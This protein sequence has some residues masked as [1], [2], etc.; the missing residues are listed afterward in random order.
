M[1]AH[2]ETSFM[3]GEIKVSPSH[4]TLWARNH[5]LKLQPKAMAVLHYLACNQHRVISNEEMIERLWA[6]RVVT[7]GSVQKSINS[8]RSA[9][10]ELIGENELIA[11]Y[12]KRGYQLMVEPQFLAPSVQE[13]ANESSPPE[14]TINSV[15]RIKTSHLMLAFAF[16]LFASA[17]LY[18][19]I[20]WGS[21]QLPHHHRTVFNT[22]QGYTNETGHERS[23]TP[24]PDNQHLAY[25]RETVTLAQT[26]ANTHEATSEIIIRNGAGKDWRIASSNGTWFKL[27]WSPAGKNLVAI[28]VKKRDGLPLGT[29]FYQPANYLYSFHIFA[30]DLAQEQLLEKQQLSQWQGHIFSVSWWDENTLEIVAKQ[31]PNAGNG[32]YRYSILDQQLTLLDELA[33]ITNPVASAVFDQALNK[34]TAIASLQKNKIQIDFLDAQQER[35]NNTKLDIAAADISWIP[36]GSGVLVYAED[37]RK[38][39]NVYLDG[40]QTSIPLADSKDKNFS[41]PRYSADGNSIYYTEEK[42]S[43]NITLAGLDGSKN[44]LTENTDFNYAASFSPDGKKVVYASVRNNQIHLWLIENGQERQLTQQPVPKKVDAIIWSDNGEHI[45]FNADNQ[46][47]HLN[48]LTNE[49]T[50]VVNDANKIEPIAYFPGTNRLYVIKYNGEIRNLWRIEGTQ[51]KQLTFGAV[52]SAIEYGGD[53]FFQYVSENGLWALRGK[54]DEIERSN[55]SLDEYS[56]LLKADSNGIYYL[57]GGVC[58]ESDV[59]YQ[60][61]SATSNPV[62]LVQENSAVLTTSFNPDKGLLQTECSLPEANIVQL[63]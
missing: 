60:D 24:H 7:H 56:K 13:T 32:R 31:G 27:A 42:R 20:N 54:N 46:L 21:V 17:A 8:L 43:A 35:I 33:T 44:R 36:D 23:A 15:R 5:S 37:E 30:L 11:H 38:L 14:A 45:V 29:R 49:S 61:Y 39:F 63:K 51:Q 62:I 53:V 22:T 26:A 50:L 58:Q 59:Y 3:L 25:I 10:N 9:L 41:R 48:L 40:Q 52:G 1:N 57:K 4:N 19:S 2:H 55:P 16:V 12:S 28:E 18:K 34:M 6:G 47:Y